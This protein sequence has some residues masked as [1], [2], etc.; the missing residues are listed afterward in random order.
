VELPD[1]LHLHLN[2]D[3][4]RDHFMAFYGL[5]NSVLSPVRMYILRDARNG[6]LVTPDARKYI[7]S[8]LNVERVAAI[9]TYG[10]SFHSRTV[11]TMLSKAMRIL[12]SSVPETAFFETEA[13]AR[14]WIAAHRPRS[15]RVPPAPR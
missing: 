8:N 12:N 15:S 1:I 11:L 2:G 9:V 14:A 7:A 5:M 3:V 13:E 4:E 6:G 10:A